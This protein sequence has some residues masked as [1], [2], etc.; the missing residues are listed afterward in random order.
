MSA[1]QPRL[2]GEFSLEGKAA[3]VT[4][5]AGGIGAAITRALAGA[6]ARVAI[7]YRT[8]ARTPDPVEET[9]AELEQL[10][11][12]R[13]L[14]VQVDLCSLESIQA[15]VAE[16]AERF[17]RIDICVNSAGTNIQQFA[18]DIDEATWDVILD[19]NLK[20]LF[21]YSQAVARVMKATP[22]ADDEWRSIVNVASQM[23]LVGLHR[24]AAYCSS[25][26]GVINLTR[27]LAI[28]WAPLGIRVNA[29]APTFINTPLAAP[30]LADPEFREDMLRRSPMGVIGEPEDVAHGVL[31]LCSPASRLVTGQ[32]LAIDGGWTAW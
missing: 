15:S 24:R 26:A 1:I 3:I 21:F 22:R 6:G 13:P 10:T 17:G 18:L 8:R 32:T 25:K 4:G 20:G 12:A 14:L 30:M 9:A 5:G 7:T 27:V 16:I 11:G 19:T 28:E 2:P 31:Y 23:G 29:V